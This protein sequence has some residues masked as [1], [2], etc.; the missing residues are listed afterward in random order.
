MKVASAQSVG[1]RTDQ[2][3]KNMHIKHFQNVLPSPMCVFCTWVSSFPGFD[4]VN[5]CQSV[6]NRYGKTI[7][8]IE[9]SY[10]DVSVWRKSIEQASM[11]LLPLTRG[12]DLMQTCAVEYQKNID[13]LVEQMHYSSKLKLHVFATKM[14]FSEKLFLESLV[15]K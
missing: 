8:R 7:E 9:G 15:W 2:L 5:F 6:E 4:F 11:Y 1:A 10:E 13:L 14:L 12:W 3:F